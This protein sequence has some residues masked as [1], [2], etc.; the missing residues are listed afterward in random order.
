MQVRNGQNLLI[1][2]SIPAEERVLLR[3]KLCSSPTPPPP[4][5][6][7]GLIMFLGNAYKLSGL[8][9]YEYN[10]FLMYCCIPTSKLGII[11]LL[12]SRP[13]L[14]CTHPLPLSDFKKCHL[15][16]VNPTPRSFYNRSPIVCGHRARLPGA[17][18]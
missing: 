7:H 6:P 8:L 16:A 12:S 10:D 17:L 5:K 11:L 1:V 9:K 13:C 18:E 4:P 14:F 2:N 15:P 3:F